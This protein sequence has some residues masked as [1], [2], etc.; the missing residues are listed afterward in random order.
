MSTL[1]SACG[2]QVLTPQDDDSA[3]GDSS[4]SATTVS[5][6]GTAPSTA[7]DS[8]GVPPDPSTDTDPP[9]IIDDF[10]SGPLDTSSDS[11]PP[12]SGCEQ[13][14]TCDACMVWET[15]VQGDDGYD[16]RL[17]QLALVADDTVI[18]IGRQDAVDNNTGEGVLVWLDADGNQL[19]ELTVFPADLELDRRV[20]GLAVAGDG[21]IA[22]LGVRTNDDVFETTL[23]L[24]DAAG[25]ELPGMA[26][27]EPDVSVVGTE[28]AFTASGAL[29]ISGRRENGLLDGF[30]RYY[31]A[32]LAL[33]WELTGT[34]LGGN[35]ASIDAID[36]TTSAIALSGASPGSLWLAVVDES[37]AVSWTADDTGL[38]GDGHAAADLVRLPGGDLVVVGW[39]GHVGTFAD[40]W[41]A[42]FDG[43]TGANVWSHVHPGDSVG[44]NGLDSVAVAADGRIFVAGLTSTSEDGRARHVD[45]ID[46]DGEVVWRWMHS[47]PGSP[48]WGTGGGL[49]W[50]PLLGVVASGGDYLDATDHRAFVTRLAS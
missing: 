8:T 27:A 5:S 50:S 21:T 45:E 39:Q 35:I 1:L 44:Q 47:N 22:V 26:M 3:S 43:A 17:D 11:G 18:A 32:E 10:G 41:V 30:V 36:A 15:F 46:C 48:D 37:G 33:Q 28:L 20:T 4:S 16:D 42:R 49:V 31:D 14:G 25:G 29:V 6:S 9:P 23:D 13:P 2:P 24:Y 12:P 34:Q 19:D 40:P 7:A 38:A